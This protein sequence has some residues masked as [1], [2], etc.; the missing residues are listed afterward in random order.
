MVAQKTEYDSLT[1]MIVD[2]HG[3]AA[4]DEETAAASTSA[5][6]LAAGFEL[7]SDINPELI[8]QDLD[9]KE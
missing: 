8:D 9:E 1:A 3:G 7:F 6:I 4:K 5:P 2:D